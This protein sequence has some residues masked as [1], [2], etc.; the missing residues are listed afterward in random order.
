[1]SKIGLLEQVEMQ[2]LRIETLEWEVAE[3]W[4][5]CEMERIDVLERR[6]AELWEKS[7]QQRIETLEYQVAELDKP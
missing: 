1:M 7:Q 4:K 6:V 2:Q 3:L 5:Q